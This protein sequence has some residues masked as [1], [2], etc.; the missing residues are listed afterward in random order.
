MFKSILISGICIL[1][2][3]LNAKMSDSKLETSTEYFRN[4]YVSDEIWG[5]LSPYFLPPTS[6]AKAYFDRIFNQKHRVLKSR[7][8]MIKSGFI[9]ISHPKDKVIVAKHP[10]LK[11]YLVKVYTDDMEAPDTYWWKKRIDGVNKIQNKIIEYGYQ[12][13]M[14]TPKKWIYPVPFSPSMGAP[15]KNFIL[16]VEEM[17]ILS[18]KKNLKAYKKKMNPKILNA[19]FT[20]MTELNLID[21]VYADNTPFCKDGKLAFIDTE[22]SLDTTCL[23]PVSVVAQYL[24]SEMYT[25][26]E[27]LI[28]NGISN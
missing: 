17:D 18:K 19:F 15:R 10:Y 4:P 20:L 26:W 16:V 11:G 1:S 23:V 27:Q 12:E 22:H 25:Y 6:M 9:M 13:I 3:V 5:T 21:S 14:K 7:K 28:V 24:S 8:S 2:N